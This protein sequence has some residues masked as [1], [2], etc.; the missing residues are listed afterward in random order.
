MYLGG[1]LMFFGERK[2]KHE[3]FI[4]SCFQLYLLLQLSQGRL[5]N[6]NIKG[7]DAQE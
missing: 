4:V 1:S 2:L 7:T 5:K 6:K 3:L